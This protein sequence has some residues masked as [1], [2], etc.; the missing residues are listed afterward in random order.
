MLISARLC[1]RALLYEGLFVEGAFGYGVGVFSP[2][3]TG[4]PVSG[5]LGFNAG[6]GYAF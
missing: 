5:E 4:A 3:V 1:V 2:A 6:V